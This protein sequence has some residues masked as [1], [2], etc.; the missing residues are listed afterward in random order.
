MRFVWDSAKAANNVQRHNV[1]F[2]EAITA[3][4]DPNALDTWDAEHSD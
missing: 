4:F 3:F 2:E 1:T